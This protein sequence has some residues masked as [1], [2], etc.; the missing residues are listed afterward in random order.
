M[1]DQF[2]MLNLVGGLNVHDFVKSTK[3]LTDAMKVYSPL[4]CISFI[5]SLETIG[6]KFLLCRIGI[7]WSGA[8]NGSG[9]S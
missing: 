5:V 6:L 3:R 7:R 2:H 9:H 1:L 8:C 4:V